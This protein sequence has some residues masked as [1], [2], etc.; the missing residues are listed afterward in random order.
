MLITLLVAA[1]APASPLAPPQE[2]FEEAIWN[3]LLINTI[4][5][6]GDQ[7]AGA[8]YQNASENPTPPEM[9]ILDLVCRPRSTGYRCSFTLVRI[10]GTDMFRDEPSPA[11]ISCHARFVSKGLR[12]GLTLEHIPPHGRRR[13]SLSTM[14]CRPTQ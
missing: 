5:G 4:I 1:A 6:T 7:V 14:R 9:R 11:R 8:W 12:E 13:H 2:H 3:D 10:G